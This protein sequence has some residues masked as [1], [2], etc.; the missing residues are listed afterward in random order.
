MTP[1]GAAHPKPVS[2]RLLARQHTGPAGGPHHLRR[3]MS[4]PVPASW[5]RIPCP[6][7]LFL[8]SPASYPC[9]PGTPTSH[10]CPSPAW[11]CVGSPVCR[12]TPGSP[13]SPAH[14]G[15]WPGASPSLSL[16][17]MQRG[18]R[19]VE[20]QLGSRGGPGP[21]PLP[22]ASQLYVGIAAPDLQKS[23]SPVQPSQAEQDQVPGACWCSWVAARWPVQVHA[24]GVM[25]CPS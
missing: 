2:P 16:C 23:R 13:H 19:Q 17:W 1:A 18:H 12:I 22:R 6:A 25:L 15:N 10:H 5:V 8:H 24:K 21:A 9:S 3:T 7:C 20:C 11:L 14:S 4:P